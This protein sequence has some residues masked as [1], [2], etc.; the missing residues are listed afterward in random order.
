[1]ADT[2]TTNLSLVKPEVGASTDTWGTKLNTDLDTIDAVFKGDGTGTSV[3]LNVGSGKVLNVAGTATI[4]GAGST[5]DATAIGATTPDTGAFTTLTASSTL[6]VT[7]AGSI[8][9]LTVGRGAGAVS[10]NTA[11]GASALAAN[12]TGANNTS[13]GQ[14]AL[15]VNTGGASNTAT[16][17]RALY[18]NTTGFNNT[19][20][21]REALHNN[22]AGEA[23]TATG[24][25]A[26][27]ANTTGS[28]NTA[29]GQQAL[30][31]NTTAS[32]N[33]AVGYQAGYSNTTGAGVTYVGD[34]AGYSTTGGSNTFV[35]D[36]AG[37]SVTTG[38][39]NTILG[40]Y[41]GNQ[42]GLDIRT[43]SNN[44]VLSDG[45]GNPRML[46]RSNGAV[47]TTDLD[48]QSYEREGY[49][50]LAGGVNQDFLLSTD[51]GPD[52]QIYIEYALAWNNGDGGAFGTALIW[53]SFDGATARIRKFSESIATPLSSTSVVMSGTN[54]SFRFTTVTGINGYWQIK[55]R[56]SKCTPNAF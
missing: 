17:R 16:G 8:Q 23:N 37:F 6:T 18:S 42:G 30:A 52:D 4:T 33:T 32:F 27:F 1:M 24:R 14:E 9:G 46:V 26:L 15:L 29:L 20:T 7:G 49:V 19:A 21:G 3:G 45:D 44:V 11:V 50:S 5:I 43:S 36:L 34:K 47:A 40:R 31:A 41:D 2:S 53:N 38:S 56:C 22:T 13:V 28:F 55:V 48:L 10:T 25:D 39:K 54:L 12:T 51:F 35:G